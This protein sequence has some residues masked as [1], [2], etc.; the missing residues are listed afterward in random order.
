LQP[1]NTARIV[2]VRPA[3]K[4]FIVNPFSKKAGLLPFEPSEVIAES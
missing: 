2:T 3:K 4:L 1:V